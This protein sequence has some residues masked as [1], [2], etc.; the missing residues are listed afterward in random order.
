MDEIINSELAETI[1]VWQKNGMK[2]DLNNLL[3]FFARYAGDPGNFIED[4][5]GNDWQGVAYQL[6]MLEEALQE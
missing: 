6:K 4:V 2:K 3:Y 5:F 1:Q